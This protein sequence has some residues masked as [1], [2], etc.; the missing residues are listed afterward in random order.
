MRNIRIRKKSLIFLVTIMLIVLLGNT[1]T[2]FAESLQQQH[3]Q[4]QQ[5]IQDTKDEQEKIRSQMTAIQKEVDDLNTKIASYESE[6]VYLSNQIDDTQKNIESAQQ[7]LEKT[8]KDLNFN[9][10]DLKCRIFCATNT[11]TCGA[12]GII[13]PQKFNAT[14]GRVP[15][16]PP[17]AF[18]CGTV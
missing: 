11:G 16:S 12:R 3:K 10:E 8:E 13:R 9:Q 1:L 15:H 14:S 6:I 7:E 17:R 4:K 2:V 18:T 5:E